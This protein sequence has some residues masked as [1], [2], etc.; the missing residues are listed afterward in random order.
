[1][2]SAL[3][4]LRPA[5]LRYH[6]VIA[7]T[8]RGNRMNAPL[9]DALRSR[10]RCVAA[11]ALLVA[12]AMLP[13]RAQQDPDDGLPFA[14][15]GPDAAMIVGALGRPAQ[16]IYPVEFIEID[17]TNIAPREVMWL[18]PGEYELTVRGFI[19]DPPG[20]R[21]AGRFRM[22]EGHNR[23]TV[24]VEAGREYAIGMKFDRD[25]PTRPYRTVLYRVE[26][27]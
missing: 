17:G 19:S 22:D 16:Y 24:T 18:A 13:A 9:V 5:A 3:P 7:D 8:E 10:S 25:E 6:G 27:D 11:A 1:V 20:L 4:A 23:I 26:D 2:V 21:S 15:P 12:A 14:R